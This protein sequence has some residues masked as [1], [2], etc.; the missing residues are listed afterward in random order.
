MKAPVLTKRASK[1]VITKPDPALMELKPGERVHHPAFGGG[2]VLSLSG[3]G[4][5]LVAEIDFGS[6]GIKRI[7]L[8]Y[9]AMK[10]EG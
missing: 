5:G 1:P 3:K 10:K 7:A 6:K 2:E 4:D 9:A 8:K